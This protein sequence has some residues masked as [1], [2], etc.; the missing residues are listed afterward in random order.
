MSGTRRSQTPE[1]LANRPGAP[2]V[3]FWDV[4]LEA[5]SYLE[6]SSWSGFEAA[7]DSVDA[8]LGSPLES[9][10][11]AARLLSALGH[12]DVEHDQRTLRPSAWSVSPTTLLAVGD[13]EWLL[14]GRRPTRLVD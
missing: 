6:D 10:R 12:I 11:D 9:A 14:C 4:L 8:V 3:G 5:L 13:A 7:F 1:S 2:G